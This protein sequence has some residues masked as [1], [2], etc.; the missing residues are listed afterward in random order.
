MVLAGG[1]IAAFGAVAWWAW[2]PDLPRA[3]LEARYTERADRRIDVLGVGLQVRESGPRDAPVVIMLHGFGASLQTWQAWAQALSDRFRVVRFDLPG[4]GLTGPDPTHDYSDAR[5]IAVLA[6]LM[7]RLGIARASLVG[8]S[9]GGRIA[10]RFAAA[11]PERVDRLV[12]AAPDGF[13]SRGFEYGRAPTVGPAV[14]LM[15]FSLPRP[16]VR[17]SLAPAYG[18]PARLTDAVLDRY[19]DL[20]LAPGVRAAMIERLRQSIL[21][22]PRAELARISA[23]TLLVWGAKDAMIPISNARDYLAVMPDARLVEFP[24][25]GHVPFEESPDETLA[26][27]RA[28][29]EA[30]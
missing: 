11:H 13:E 19:R 4:F 26:P 2:T 20:M 16:L 22:D 14:R 25:L 27:V 9:L 24:A 23:P 21:Q 28:F 18:D 17:M 7:D 5:S 10:G 6:G 8:N 29:L 15:R 12:L 1:M 3:A 30:G